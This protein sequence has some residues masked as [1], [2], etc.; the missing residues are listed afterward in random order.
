MPQKKST[1]RSSVKDEKVYQRVREQGASKE[2]AARIAN[3][4][5]K[6]GRSQVGKRG[7][8]SPSYDDWSK[9]DL[10]RRAR[11]I[12]IAGRSQMNKGE[13]INAIRHHFRRWVMEGILPPAVQ[14]RRAKVDFKASLSAG[15]ARF[16]QPLVDD[17]LETDGMRI[18]PFVEL[19]AV[20][21]A[22]RRL[23]ENPAEAAMDDIQSVWRSVALSLWLRQIESK[24][25]VQ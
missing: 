9:E 8:K 7:G 10:Q 11:Q 23:A 15:I 20:K 19:A 3:A 5:N 17:L 24:G 14:W 12:G 25:T 13:L 1:R 21:A 6:S 18:A 22:Y 2:K 16:H 4:A